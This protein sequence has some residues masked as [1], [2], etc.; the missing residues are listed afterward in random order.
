MFMKMKMRHWLA[1]KIFSSVKSVGKFIFPSLFLC[2]VFCVQSQAQNTQPSQT[3]VTQPQTFDFTKYGVRI[4]PD[5]R[6]I[7]VMASLEFAGLET[8]LTPQGEAFRKRLREDLSSLNADTKQRMQIFL[9]QYKRRHPEQT[10]EQ[11]AASFISLAYA[12]SPVPELQDPERTVD[13]PADLLEV[14]DFA[15]LVREFYRRSGISAKLEEYYK[16][17]QAEGDKMRSSTANMVRKLLDYLHTRPQ[18]T[19]LEKIKVETKDAK[20]K[21]TIQK[22]ETRERE[23]RFFVVPDLLAPAGTINFRNIADDYYVI[24]PPGTNLSFSEARR[25]FLRFVFDPLTFQNSKDI[26]GF[27]DRIRELLEERRKSNP[28]ISIDVFLADA[29]SIA[30]AADVRQMEFSKIQQATLQ[31]RRRI[32]AAKSDDE[33]RAI[34]SELA[35]LKAELA[36]ESALLLSEAYEKGAV[37]TFHFAEQLKGVEEAGFDVSAAFRDMIL[38]INFAKE[39][40]R[41]SEFAD[42]RR[43]ALERQERR[44]ATQQLELSPKEKVLAQKLTEVEEMV[45]RKEFEQAD[46][47]LANLLMVYPGDPRIFYARGRV[48]SL[49]AEVTFDEALRNERLERA[50]AHYRNVILLA[51]SDT[52]PVLIQRA[53]VALAR[54]FEFNEEME[55]AL[56]QYNEAIKIGNVDE[57]AYREA[58]A[59]RERLTKKP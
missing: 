2:A 14:L 37:L 12:L 6:L 54:I 7:V 56:Q 25:A 22:I 23:R 28:D 58:L 1:S 50:A 35:Q 45:K 30:V 20:G 57:Q 40:Q 43:R 4:E 53:H 24:V 41:L 16:L 13:L 21:N 18:V 34:A 9:S 3:Q 26:I 17:Y 5:R 31:A 42:A 47:F 55:A 38:S 49:Y 36:D 19:Y 48:A 27:R 39:K 11:I 8:N 44:K 52:D 33:K 51:T 15:P 59:G 29:R 32:D 46:E 10:P